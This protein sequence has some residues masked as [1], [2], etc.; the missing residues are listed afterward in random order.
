MD[1]YRALLT[2]KNSSG[3]QINAISSHELLHWEA[4]CYQVL[5]VQVILEIP[6]DFQKKLNHAGLH[7]H[8]ERHG[9][10]APAKPLTQARTCNNTRIIHL[11]ASNIL[12]YCRITSGEYSREEVLISWIKIQRQDEQFIEWNWRQFP[13]R[14]T[15]WCIYIYTTTIVRVRH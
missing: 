14:P 8:K 7:P 9:P 15:Q 3:D 10:H 1:Y 6:P 5:T 11:K 2:P 13:V 12:L 4:T